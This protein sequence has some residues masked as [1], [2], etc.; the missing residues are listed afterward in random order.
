MSSR[1]IDL[2]LS[3]MKWRLAP[4]LDIDF[5]RSIKV[6]ILGAGTLGCNIAR[7]LVGWGISK[8]VLVDNGSVSLSNP[9]RQ[10]LYRLDMAMSEEPKAK[11]AAKALLEIHPELVGVATLTDIGDRGHCLGSPIAQKGWRSQ[12]CFS[13]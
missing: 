3:L 7:G 4:E 12:C 5:L 8:F 13:G 2:N 11:A 10:S 6:G 9:A 1:A